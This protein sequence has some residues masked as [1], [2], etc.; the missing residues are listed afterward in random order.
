MNG[1]G[2]HHSHQHGFGLLNAWRLVNAAK[3]HTYARRDTAT[4]LNK[5][6]HSR[7]GWRC[8]WFLFQVWES[9]PFLLSYQS[10]VIKEETPIVI[11]PDELVLTWEGNPASVSTLLSQLCTGHLL[12]KFTHCTHVAN[13]LCPSLSACLLLSQAACPYLVMFSL[14]VSSLGEIIFPDFFAGFFSHFL[15][16]FSDITTLTFLTIHFVPSS[17]LTALNL[18]HSAIC[19]CN[20]SLVQ[21]FR[22]WWP[23]SSRNISF[24]LIS[25]SPPSICIFPL[26]WACWFQEYSQMCVRLCVCAQRAAVKEVLYSTFSP[27]SVVSVSIGWGSFFLHH[28]RC[29]DLPVTLLGVCCGSFYV[30]WLTH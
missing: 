21:F 27:L 14:F 16:F 18:S 13:S 6:V 5:D 4:A 15:Q 2:F 30:F 1:A 17:L 19:V 11:Y 10:S 20:L 28:W 22:I 9:V 24:S 29:S 8:L 25:S 3:V 23:H 26:L 7:L 12:V